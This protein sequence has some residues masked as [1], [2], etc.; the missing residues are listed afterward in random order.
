VIG[1]G[2][3]GRKWGRS[4]DFIWSSIDDQ[5]TNT[6]GPEIP[7]GASLSAAAVAV[8]IV[9]ILALVAAVVIVGI[10]I[11]FGYYKS[12][13]HQILAMPTYYNISL[14]RNSIAI[15]PIG[16]GRLPFNLTLPFGMLKDQ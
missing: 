12:K 4:H 3:V 13:H 6:V 16:Y 11:I 2:G 8:P 10:L 5:R 15:F 14:L 9:L 1:R 7:N